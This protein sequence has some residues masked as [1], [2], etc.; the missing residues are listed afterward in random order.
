MDDVA[1]CNAF[2]TPGAVV[3]MATYAHFAVVA[4]VNILRPSSR[5]Y[6]ITL[7][8]NSALFVIFGKVF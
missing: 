2:A 3:V 8:T 6:D 5:L 4:M 1:V 7:N